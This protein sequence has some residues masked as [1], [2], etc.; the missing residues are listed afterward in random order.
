[1][2]LFLVYPILLANGSYV[3]GSWLLTAPTA[4]LGWGKF[5]FA[6]CM[7]GLIG[8]SLNADFRQEA[9]SKPHVIGAAVVA[10][11]CAF[12][13]CL[14]RPLWYVGLVVWLGWLAYYLIKQYKNKKAG[15][16]DAFSL[17]MELVAFY[18]MPT[19]LTLFILF[20]LF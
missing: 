16:P 4:L 1:M 8:V 2:C 6:L 14:M 17:Y 20:N 7:G 9:E 19:C 13:A 18:S 11:G 15:N 10:G 12:A 5:L 3:D